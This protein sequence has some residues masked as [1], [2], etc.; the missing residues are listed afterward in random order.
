[1]DPE[2][3]FAE[4]RQE[5]L[6]QI[7]LHAQMASDVIHTESLSA[8]VMDAMGTVPRHE[9]VPDELRAFAYLDQPLPIGCG[10][11]ISQPFIVA[12]MTHLLDVQREDTVLDVGTGLGYQAAILAT[13]AGH[14]YSSEI[15]PE[16]A[17][18]ATTRLNRLGFNNVDVRT[19]DGCRSWACEAPFDKVLVAAAAE[20]IPVPLLEQLKPGGRMVIPCGLPEL[21]HLTLVTKNARGSIS[22]EEVLPVL[23]S[24]LVIV[25]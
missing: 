3:L 14:V 6:E 16:L 20:L 8:S 18:E 24:S 12:L 17:H 22:T 11:T 13:L 19:G 2:P 10:K 4:A 1:M 7:A 15:V 25:H 5:M 21:Q 23:F 9:F